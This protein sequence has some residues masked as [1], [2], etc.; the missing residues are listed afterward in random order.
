MTRT[1]AIKS[2]IRKA[3]QPGEAY[4]AA[5]LRLQKAASRPEQA[6]LRRIIT[7]Y[8]HQGGYPHKLHA[9][10]DNPSTRERMGI[11]NLVIQGR[12]LCG[13]PGG[14]IDY[15]GWRLVSAPGDNMQLHSGVDFAPEDTGYCQECVHTWREQFQGD[16][17][18]TKT[19]RGCEQD[20]PLNKFRVHKGRKDGLASECEDC[21]RAAKKK[22]DLAREAEQ[23]A[24]RLAHKRA[25]AQ[26]WL[27]R[28]N[29]W[30]QTPGLTP[31]RCMEGHQLAA[32][33]GEKN[34]Q[35]W[36]SWECPC[37]TSHISQPVFKL[38]EALGLAQRQLGS[39]PLVVTM[40]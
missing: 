34:F 14:S 1:R 4:N 5:A 17:E 7:A 29:A 23:R 33:V 16:T 30:Q 40:V 19:C 18:E 20:R 8:T 38:I 9:L 6:P 27:A 15:G 11:G 25:A 32:V 21:R 24:E 37:G 36:L 12:A 26:D 10:I 2:D 31:F 13:N 39:N 3:I 22:A 28:V 35:M